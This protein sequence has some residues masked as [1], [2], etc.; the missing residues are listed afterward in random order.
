MAEK[1]RKRAGDVLALVIAAGARATEEAL[2][3]A[4]GPL[5][6]DARR[7]P[8]RL[9]RPVR[10][11]VSS[12]S[13]RE[14]VAARLVTR[15]GA[16]AGVTV[17]TLQA[18][19]REVLER[20]GQRLGDGDAL[21]SLLARR[22]V[23]T[24][25][26]LRDLLADL[27]DGPGTAIGTIADLLDAGLTEATATAAE[28]AL[29]E[30]SKFSAARGHDHERARALVRAASVAARALDAL[31]CARSSGRLARASE[32]LAGA[33]PELL[34]SR[35]TLIHGFA[36]ATRVALDLIET[37]V[38][39][40]DATVFV[41]R[42]PDP[43]GDEL[44]AAPAR[45]TE[46][47]ICAV[48]AADRAERLDEARREPVATAAIELLAAPGENAEARAVATR[49]RRLLDEGAVS[50]SIGIVARRLDPYLI[51]LRRHL[52]RLGIAFSSTAAAPP[53]AEERRAHAFVRLLREGGQASAESLLDA[54]S[55]RADR[56]NDLRVACHAVGA[57][58]VSDVAALD[59][60]ELVGERTGLSLP[61]PRG[62]ATPA[63]EDDEGG[64]ATAEEGE[65]EETSVAEATS[66]RR[67]HVRRRVVERDDLGAVVAAAGVI[68][69]EID[70]S[71]A[72]GP[73]APCLLGETLKRIA[74]A[75]TPWRDA[76]DEVPERL[77]RRAARVLVA[78]PPAVA[79][80]FGE[81]VSLIER[82]LLR[83]SHGL[84]GGAGCGVAVLDAMAARA[85]TFEHLFV[86]GLNRDLFPRIVREDPLLPDALRS[87]IR[88][89]SG[90]ELGRKEAGHDEE[91][92]LFASLLSASPRI[93]LCWQRAGEDGKERPASP[94]L[95]LLRSNRPTLVPAN[96]PPLRAAT[97]GAIEFPQ[98]AHE[99]AVLAG[100]HADRATHAEM[101]VLALDESAACDTERPD[102]ARVAAAQRAVLEAFDPPPSDEFGRGP[103]PW[104]GFTGSIRANTES[105]HV[106]GAERIARCGWRDF[107]ERTLGLEPPPDALA[108][109][110]EIDALAIGSAMHLVLERWLCSIGVPSRRPLTE[111][112]ETSGV[113][114]IWPDDTGLRQLVGS[115]VR[116][117]LGPVAIS[118][119]S[120]AT[121]FGSL[122]EERFRS[123]RTWDGLAAGTRVL[124]SEVEGV[125]RLPPA[126]PVADVRFRADLVTR[127]EN[128]LQLIDLKTGKATSATAKAIFGRVR[129]G[130]ALQ[131]ALYATAAAELVGREAEGVYLHAV[132]EPKS[133][134]LPASVV[135]QNGALVPVLATI[136]RAW[137]LGARPPQLADAAGDT[138]RAC[139]HCDVAA[140]CAHGDSTLR[141]EFT[142]WRDRA[143]AVPGSSPVEAAALAL[144]RLGVSESGG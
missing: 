123:L 35:A 78:I 44:D 127:T 105:L 138:P 106:T 23:L 26:L 17:Q 13:L 95:E 117:L 133:I 53:G 83:P 119:P 99:M 19:A 37:L 27:E 3:D 104:S 43:A 118:F 7:E 30:P 50:E 87:R 112:V 34:P 47:L 22:A 82:E 33:D 91:R 5:L 143:A 98:T 71:V 64:E 86:L 14:H 54:M 60:S 57:A 67:S 56:R 42:P 65:E 114:L 94:L 142:L 120:V 90:L 1:E 24:E 137:S 88:A 128:R 8:A 40:H 68:A 74:E 16:M 28:E 4:I 79:P 11:V 69:S 115:V 51:P 52:T 96:V 134:S 116:E 80:T 113:A 12:R 97:A 29:A 92:W 25:P 48:R 121:Q 55:I 73:S 102:S 124:G 58:R 41:D 107:L 72:A 125:L 49:I 77:S 46:R 18:L 59:V 103:G 39:H 135:E 108:A 76:G 31:G 20:A 32:C 15:F 100:L 111:I 81:S 63:S 70:R 62:R 132:E 38:R 10:I 130:T 85:R 2:F 75:L 61:V 36:D 126:S 84:A 21:F 131:G 93:T 101:L 109:L 89:G 136:A 129:K 66:D 144:L 45:F 110:P 141:R 139:R 122:L 9:A 140:A 6:A